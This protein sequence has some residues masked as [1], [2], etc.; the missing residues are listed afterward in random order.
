[1]ISLP[2]GAMAPESWYTHAMWETAT[3]QRGELLGIL[4]S[5]IEHKHQREKYPLFQAT[6]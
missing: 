4:H 5:Y 1:M 3:S 6:P 2:F